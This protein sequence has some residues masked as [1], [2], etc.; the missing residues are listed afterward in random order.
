[1]KAAIKPTVLPTIGPPTNPET[2]ITN[3]RVFAMEALPL[4]RLVNYWGQSDS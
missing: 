2:P 1:M 4:N 3:V